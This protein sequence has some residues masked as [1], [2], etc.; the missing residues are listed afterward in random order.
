MP[1]VRYPLMLL[2][3]LLVVAVV[4][5]CGE[6]GAD[7]SDTADTA[8]TDA[9][10]GADTDDTDG[11]DTDDAGN[12][13]G[14]AAGNFEG[15]TL[16]FLI[17]RGPGGGFDSYARAL[18]PY[19]ADEVGAEAVFE[20]MPGA[21]GLLAENEI[22]NVL[23]ADCRTIGIMNPRG[24]MS[25]Q[26]AGDPAVRFDVRE[27]FD[28]LGRLA[29][30]PT[31]WLAGAHTG[32]ESVEDVLEA[33]EFSSGAS[34]AAS[35]GASTAL[36]VGAAFELDWDLVTGF[37]GTDETRLA[38]ER[39]E[40]DG[41]V[42][43]YAPAI[44]DV[45]AGLLVPLLTIGIEPHELGPDIPI[46]DDVEHLLSDEGRQILQA[47]ARLAA[48]SRAFV[49]RSGCPEEE[50][51]ELRD[52]HARMMEN[53]EMLEMMEAEDNPVHRMDSPEFD[54]LIHQILDEMPE[55]FVEVLRE[56]ME[57]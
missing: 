50:L 48:A 52:A 37:D 51:Q 53:E 3:F 26:A 47:P 15:D 32:Y 8:D 5:G 25:A 27:D 2:L 14:E 33:G 56:G 9:D 13:D 46:V 41:I 7:D 54:E 43:S 22:A 29:A 10:D 38:V 35:V 30:E 36:A 44:P 12:G 42:M 45:E 49:V 55:E 1:R 4:A 17:G 24:T 31:V 34:G 20:N 21:G 19:L 18:G 16:N 6:D 28:F 39:Q 23:P 11:A 57:D 40:L